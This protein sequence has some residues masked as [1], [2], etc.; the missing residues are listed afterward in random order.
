M[1]T[2]ANC[3]PEAFR[4]RYDCV[5]FPQNTVGRHGYASV[6]VSCLLDAGALGVGVGVSAAGPL[7]AS[8][9]SSETFAHKVLAEASI[10]PDASLTH[11]LVSSWLE[12][13]LETPGFSSL[14]DL[15][16]LYFVGEVPDAVETFVETHLLKG[17]KVSSTTTNSGPSGHGYR[18]GGLVAYL[19]SSPVP[20][21]AGLRSRARRRH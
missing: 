15:H 21:P 14:I 6:C 11:K 12:S 2:V 17:A 9:T 10:P 3:T 4:K 19:R 13:P 18:F 5:K 20:R 16:R 7:P 8:T 1:T